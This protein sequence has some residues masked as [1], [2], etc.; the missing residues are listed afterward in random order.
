MT[1]DTFPG[2]F[3][4]DKEGKMIK[5]LTLFDVSNPAPGEQVMAEAQ[6]FRQPNDPGNLAPVNSLQDVCERADRAASITLALF[7]R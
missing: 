1:H 7:Q 3:E 6:A 2:L 4:I 5:F